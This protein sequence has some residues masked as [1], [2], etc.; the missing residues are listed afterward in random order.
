MTYTTY[1]RLLRLFKLNLL[2][3]YIGYTNVYLK[4]SNLFKG[5]LGCLS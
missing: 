3:G 5:D 4:N 2:K 1:L